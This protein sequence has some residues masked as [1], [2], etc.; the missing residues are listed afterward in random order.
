MFIYG[1]AWT[2]CLIVESLLLWLA[3]AL[4]ALAMRLMPALSKRIDTQDLSD[5]VILPDRSALAR[6]RVRP[7]LAPALNPAF[8]R[9][10]MLWPLH[11]LLSFFQFNLLWFLLFSCLG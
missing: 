10:D 11:L 4:V 9:F 5:P 2:V 7:A 3:G 6:L 8:F 1:F